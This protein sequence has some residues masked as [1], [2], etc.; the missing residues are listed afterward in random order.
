MWT[1]FVYIKNVIVLCLSINNHCTKEIQRTYM[2]RIFII[3]INVVIFLSDMISLDAYRA[4]IGRGW[5]HRAQSVTLPETSSRLHECRNHTG[6]SRTMSWLLRTYFGGLLLLLLVDFFVLHIPP[7]NT[8][9]GSTGSSTSST[10]IS[11]R[12]GGFLYRD[13]LLQIL[14]PAKQIQL[15]L[16]MGG[17]EL[18]P[19]PAI[20]LLV[21]EYCGEE[22]KRGWNLKRH[23][24]R[25]HLSIINILCHYCKKELNSVQEL[26][27][28]MLDR[29][30]PRTNRWQETNSSFKKDVIDLT[31]FYNENRL[32]RAFS[33]SVLRSALNQLVWY[34][35]KFGSL[36]FSLS[37]SALMRK[38]VGGEEIV[39][40]FFF[41]GEVQRLQK[42]SFQ[43]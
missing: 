31:Y 24:Q 12:E 9:T 29:H 33:E 2:D 16:I 4:I 36:K 14:P 41:Q 40:S 39:D 32:E 21:C 25:Q 30:K 7:D 3:I 17:I 42:N 6:F 15:M 5:S 1:A 35:R 8:V 20:K 18:N 37:F 43:K 34:R 27:T 13:E 23:I 28:H 22:F 11:N 26:Q 10:D 38:N 19:G